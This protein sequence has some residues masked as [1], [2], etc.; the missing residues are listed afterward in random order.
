MIKDN[1]CYSKTFGYK[2][3]FVETA[4]KL[5]ILDKLENNTLFTKYRATLINGKTIEYFK[6]NKCS[7]IKNDKYIFFEDKIK[8]YITEN[9]NNNTL[10]SY[11]PNDFIKAIKQ[12]E[13]YLEDNKDEEIKAFELHGGIC[14]KDSFSE[15]IKES[16]IYL[17]IY[18]L[19]QQY[20][21]EIKKNNI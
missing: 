16:N 7:W 9:N 8:E 20:Q 5:G 13:Q 21:L 14:H 10:I 4:I 18:Q 3:I 6:P 17:E 15:E 12:I 1:T 19:L 2:V 11:N